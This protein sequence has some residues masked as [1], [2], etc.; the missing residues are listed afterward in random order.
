MKDIDHKIME[1][2]AKA[3]DEVG[4]VL[5]TQDG[6]SFSYPKGFDV[7]DMHTESGVFE[8]VMINRKFRV[9]MQACYHVDEEV[10]FN[11]IVF[12]LLDQYTYDMTLTEVMERSVSVYEFVSGWVEKR[13]ILKA[14]LTNEK[15]HLE[16]KADA[17]NQ[18]SIPKVRRRI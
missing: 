4:P 16:V 3:Q 10:F 9:G 15:I 7:N 13:P 8:G 5:L 17:P 12:D 11:E 1:A 14:L 2:I 6:Y 18:S